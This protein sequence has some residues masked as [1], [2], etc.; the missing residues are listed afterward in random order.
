ME[1]NAGIPQNCLFARNKDL[2]K[3]KNAVSYLYDIETPVK[4]KIML[5][6]QKAYDK[7]GHFFQ[8][9]ELDVLTLQ[10]CLWMF[11]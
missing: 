1:E 7:I 11:I 4:I 9:N 5:Y 2:K 3:K 6:E 8:P 10:Y